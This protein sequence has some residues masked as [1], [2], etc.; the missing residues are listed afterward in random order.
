MKKRN[1]I[2]NIYKWDLSCYIKDEE[3]MK[4]EFEYLE[5]TYPIFK[6]YYGMFNDKN[7]LLEF[8]KLNDEFEIRF[9]RLTCYVYH[10]LD[11]DK[12]NTFY[13]S[14]MKKLEFLSKDVSELTAF[15][16]PQL[17]DLDEN[18]LKELINDENFEE[19]KRELSIILKNK[20]HKLSEHDSE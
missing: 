19:Y 10:S 6:N 18:Y 1:E 5:K 12:S 9:D 17:L 14:Y 13:L 11:E 4:K 7:K 2:E 3:M 20:E 8:F 15:V 16:S